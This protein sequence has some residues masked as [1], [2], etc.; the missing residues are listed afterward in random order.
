MRAAVHKG[1]PRPATAADFCIAED[2]GSLKSKNILAGY[3]AVLL[4]LLLLA[5]LAVPRPVRAEAT[6]RPEQT[7]KQVLVILASDCCMPWYE[8]VA[9]SISVTFQNVPSPYQIALHLEYAG[10]DNNYNDAYLQSLRRLYQSKYSGKK[11][12]LVVAVSN[13]TVEF[14]LKYRKELFVNVPMVYIIEPKMAAKVRAQPNMTGIIGTAKAGDNLELALGLHPGTKHVAVVSGISAHDQFYEATARAAFKKYEDRLDFIYLTGLST[15]ELLSKLSNLP[16]KT[17]IFYMLTTKNS[18]GLPVIP[19][20]EVSIIARRANAPVY[21]LWDTLLGYGIIGG[22]LSSAEL[23]GSEAARLGLR[24]LSGEKAGSIPCIEGCYA[25]LFDWR[26][27]RKWGIAESDLPPGSLVRYEEFSFLDRYKWQIILVAASILAAAAVY[28]KISSHVYAKRLKKQEQVQKMLESQVEERTASLQAANAELAR[29]SNIDG[30]TS[31]FNRRYFDARLDEEWRRHR[32][33]RSPLSLLMCDL[34]YFKQFNDTYGHQTGDS[35]LQAVAQAA[36]K[37]LKR[38]SDIA[39]RYGGEEFALVLTDTDLDG[40]SKIAQDILTAVRD[41]AIPHRASTI[42]PVV[43]VSIGV[44][45]AVPEAEE[46]AE[47]M[48]QLADQALYRSKRDGR[49]R[50]EVSRPR[51]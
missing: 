51:A 48:V 33:G 39:A 34:D 9:Q 28:I 4:V 5:G 7:P 6:A 44:A 16:P 25:Y 27:M 14:L 46:E 45:S 32:R 40:A 36:K 21:S 35:C 12:D 29:L 38:P 30:L 2:M 47:A 13:M 23:A 15:N 49:N 20:D 8:I 1:E 24:I 43:T 11:L 50:V 17:I 41:L 31:L 3:F 26:Q 19:R 37:V 18:A 10:L 42:A 22:Y